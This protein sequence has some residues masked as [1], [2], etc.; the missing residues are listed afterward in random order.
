MIVPDNSAIGAKW[1]CH[2]CQIKPNA[3][4]S[5][6]KYDEVNETINIAPNGGTTG[7]YQWLRVLK[8]Q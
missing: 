6:A 1:E 3:T 2:E 5:A 4:L 8:A 7:T